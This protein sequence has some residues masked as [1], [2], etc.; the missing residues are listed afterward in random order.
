MHDTHGV[1]GSRAQPI[2]VSVGVKG[3]CPGC[4]PK[5]PPKFDTWTISEGIYATGWEGTVQVTA[6]SDGRMLVQ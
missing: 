4:D 2:T 3:A 5:R 6:T 1:L